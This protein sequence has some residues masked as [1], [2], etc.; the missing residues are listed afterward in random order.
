VDVEY[1]QAQ[2]KSLTEDVEYALPNVA[3]SR[4]ALRTA[5]SDADDLWLY[6]CALDPD[7]EEPATRHALAT[8]ARLAA[9]PFAV[10]ARGTIPDPL[11]TVDRWVSAMLLAV[12]A[13]DDTLVDRLCAAPVLP[14][15]DFV[16]AW[17][18]C[19]RAFMSRE[20]V[21][22]TL[23]TEAMEGTDPRT[24]VEAGVMDGVLMLNY[25]QIRL[26][27]L[28]MSRDEVGFNEA[29]VVALHDFKDFTTAREDAASRAQGFVAVGLLAL[30][31]LGRR[32]G[33]SVRVESGYLPRHLLNGE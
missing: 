16:D 27:H 29:L 18:G 30:A 20:P 9:E 33:L 7:A 5:V 15:G 23:V 6:R 24:R 25:P 14:S 13:R 3:N 32:V 11:T 19:L 31:I 4:Y 1:A 28:L 8:A 26:F 17:A 10:V 2:V 21:P 22:S 12:V